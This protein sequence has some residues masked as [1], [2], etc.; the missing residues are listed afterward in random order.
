MTMED[1]KRG[2][3]FLEA[4]TIARLYMSDT[5]AGTSTGVRLNALASELNKF[6]NAPLGTPV[7]AGLGGSC[8]TAGTTGSGIY[9]ATISGRIATLSDTGLMATRAIY[10][11]H[12]ED[13]AG[14]LLSGALLNGA[15]AG[16]LTTGGAQAGIVLPFAGGTTTL[17]IN[18]WVAGKIITNSTGAAAL[19]LTS[20]G[21]GSVFKA[22]LFLHLANGLLITGTTYTFT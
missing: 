20:T 22:V 8:G 12:L 11:Y 10:D 18:A 17:P 21:A 2:N 6:N 4:V 3:Q 19:V 16:G 1:R 7:F 15:S 14:V 13:T 9:R 5:D